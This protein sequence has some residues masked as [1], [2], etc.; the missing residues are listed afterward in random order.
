MHTHVFLFLTLQIIPDFNF[1]QPEDEKE[2]LKVTLLCI[3]SSL[4]GVLSC[5]S[6]FIPSLRNKIVEDQEHISFLLAGATGSTVGSIALRE[7]AAEIIHTAC[8]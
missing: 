3:D 6:D 1:C 2:Y 5:L 4:Q 7:K 8:K